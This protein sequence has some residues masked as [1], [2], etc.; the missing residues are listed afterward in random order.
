MR[1][2]ILTKIKSSFKQNKNQD[3]D[4]IAH[5]KSFVKA[6]QALLVCQID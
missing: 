3:Q 5:L 6:S 4:I 2:K 1:N